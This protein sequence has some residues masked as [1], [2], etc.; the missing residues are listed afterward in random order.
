M[1]IFIIIKQIGDLK[2]ILP[3]GYS[4]WETAKQSAKET[5]EEIHGR[6]FTDFK[7]YS[8]PIT[9]KDEKFNFF[10]KEIKLT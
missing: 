2:E 3:V 10:S 6:G 7:V 5:R 4:D 8:F 1:E 9:I